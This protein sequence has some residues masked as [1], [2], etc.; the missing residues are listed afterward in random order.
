MRKI[1][2][3]FG[4]LIIA[5]TSLVSCNVNKEDYVG[6]WMGETRDSTIICLSLQEDGSFTE[7]ITTFDN[8]SNEVTCKMEG[9]WSINGKDIEATID[10]ATVVVKN[11]RN[12]NNALAKNLEKSIKEQMEKKKKEES[13]I[14][15]LASISIIPHDENK[16]NDPDTLMGTYPTQGS[17]KLARVPNAKQ[18][19]Q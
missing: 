16:P 14:K 4:L 3:F 10:P 15:V 8:D 13:K 18:V 12:E 11:S 7:S 5:S 9:Q 17:V 1:L 2:Y 19:K 6:E